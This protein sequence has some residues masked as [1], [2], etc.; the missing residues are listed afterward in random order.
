MT[1]NSRPEDVHRNDPVSDDEEVARLR[2][3]L[4]DYSLEQLEAIGLVEWDRESNIVRRG[5]SFGDRKPP[6]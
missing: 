3:L 6:I 4:K 2:L 5:P 1:D